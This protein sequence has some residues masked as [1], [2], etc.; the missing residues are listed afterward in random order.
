M[1]DCDP[2][3]QFILLQQFS[4]QNLHIAYFPAQIF[5]YGHIKTVDN[6]LIC[7]LVVVND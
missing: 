1:L 4:I 3:L 2:T 6:V 5:T 7:D